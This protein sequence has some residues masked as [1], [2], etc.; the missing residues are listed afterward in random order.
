MQE[1]YQT[2]L[3]TFN[4]VYGFWIGSVAA[5]MITFPLLF[6]NPFTR[7][8]QTD[9]IDVILL[10]AVV[11]ALLGAI[12]VGVWSFLQTQT[13]RNT[14]FITIP[15]NS[16]FYYRLKRYTYVG[17]AG[18]AL[19]GLWFMPLLWVR[20]EALRFLSPLTALVFFV[21]LLVYYYQ[22][23]RAY[24]A[25]LQSLPSQE[26]HNAIKAAISQV[27]GAW[28]SVLLVVFIMLITDVFR[29]GF[30]LFPQ[31]ADE[32]MTT[33]MILITTLLFLNQIIQLWYYRRQLQNVD[34]VMQA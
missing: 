3:T 18:I 27:H 2:L 16:P 7:N 22:S 25:E 23:Y 13:A 5:L 20:S 34:E 19:V 31:V 12:V 6:N 11:T 10:V 24:D 1:K 9:I 4:R 8:S 21:M 15:Q 30:V 26:R 17:Y 32:W 28:F 14:F 33:A 29:N